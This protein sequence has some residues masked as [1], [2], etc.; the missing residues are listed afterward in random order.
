MSRVFAGAVRKTQP[1]AEI[2]Q[3]LAAE[4]ERYLRHWN[5]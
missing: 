4:A 3:E 1:A 5:D 2:M